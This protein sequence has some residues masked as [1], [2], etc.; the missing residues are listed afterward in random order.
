MLTGI[1]P[2]YPIVALIHGEPA[3]LN[4]QNRSFHM[5]QPF[6]DDIDVGVGQFRALDLGLGGS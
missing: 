2:G 1:P 4:Q 3:A 5:S 6:A